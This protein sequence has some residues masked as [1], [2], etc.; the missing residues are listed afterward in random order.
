MYLKENIRFLRKQAGLT[1]AEL[2]AKLGLNRPVIGAYEEGRAEPRIQTL[3]HLAQHFG[4]RVDELLGSDLSAGGPAV[5]MA[6][7]GLRI[8]P[9][10]TDTSSDKEL[11]TLV[12]VKAA[13]GY[14]GGYGDIEYIGSLPHFNLPFPELPMDRSYRVFQIEGES[15]LPIPPKS[16]IVCEYVQDWNS[17]RYNERH[18]L[19]TQNDGVVF[20]R[21]RP[22]DDRPAFTLHSDN[23][24][25]APFDVAAED[26]LEV[27]KARGFCTFDM[28]SYRGGSA[29]KEILDRLD[30]LEARR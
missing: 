4:C 26:V 24:D 13:A 15:M 14:L 8:L 20:K 9:I 27:W 21:V 30:R 18:I 1:Q 3:M 28:D 25:Y 2:A 11:A 10:V 19:L 16:Y 12:P 29:M 17:I 23:A 7:R 5:D 6:G 22:H